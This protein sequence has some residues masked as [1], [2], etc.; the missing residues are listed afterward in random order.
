M[1]RFQANICLILVTFCWSAEV[2]ITACVPEDVVPFALTSITSL[3]GGCLLWFLFRGRIKKCIEAQ[4]KKQILYCFGLSALNCVYNVLFM[5]GWKYFDVSSGAFLICFTAVV[6]PFVLI[7]R[8]ESVD[9]K[10]WLSSALIFCG[11]LCAIAGVVVRGQMP[12]LILIIIG[13]AMRVVFTCMLNKY[14]K[15][16]DP[17]VISTFISLFVGVIAFVLWSVIQ[18]NTFG[19]IEWEGTTI[20]SL[21]VYSYFIIAFA[22][23]VNIFAQR[24]TTVSNATV[25]YS[26]EIVFSI[27][28]GAVVPS[29]RIDPVKVTPRIILGLIFV[30]V[31]N[32]VE[33]ADFGKKKRL[34]EASTGGEAV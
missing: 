28:L 10:T 22:Q 25:I 18:R 16:Y 6:M 21:A 7:V 23:T 1:N 26:V 4:S 15:E 5:T 29:M 8:R 17:V 27:I 13:C 11:V 32:L 9:K 12:G 3:I 2:I 20:A 31:G 14:V 30:V 19:A 33:I 34:S 24:R